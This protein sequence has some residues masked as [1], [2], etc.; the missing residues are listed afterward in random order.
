MAMVF[1]DL[2]QKTIVSDEAEKLDKLCNEYKESF[3]VRFTQTNQIV[4]DDAIWFINTLFFVPKPK[5]KPVKGAMP[6]GP[7]IKVPEQ[8]AKWT[9]CTVCGMRWKFTHFRMCPQKHGIEGLP[10][11]FHT[12]YKE[13]WDGNG[14]GNGNKED[15]QTF[16]SI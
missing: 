2:S 15:N 14:D 12:R 1:E 13:I 7:K 10:K 5:A 8:E 6:I 4:Y 3:T 9:S 16:K 11:E